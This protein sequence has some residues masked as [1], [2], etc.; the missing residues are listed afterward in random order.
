MTIMIMI[1]YDG[2]DDDYEDDNDD[3]DDIVDALICLLKNLSNSRRAASHS[4]WLRP[5]Q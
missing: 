2:D 4:Y 3:D 5:P 1:M